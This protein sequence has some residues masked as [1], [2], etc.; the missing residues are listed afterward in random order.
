MFSVLNSGVVIVARDYEIDEKNM[1]LKLYRPSIINGSQTQGVI[2][3]FLAEISEIPLIHVKFEL[4][5]STDDDLI[6]EISIA[7]NYQNDVQSVSILGRR[8]VF[9]DLEIALQKVFPE[10]KLQKS[11]TQRPS[12]ENDYISTEKLIQVIAALLPEELWW[13]SE[14]FSKVYVYNRKATCLKD[15]Q[16]IWNSAKD[17][18]HRL[19]A[20]LK[21]AYS[22]YLSVV[23]I[24]YH[25]YTKWKT[26]QNFKGTGL[27]AIVRNNDGEIVEVPD[28]IIFPIL[29]AFSVFVV[30]EGDEWVL[31]IPKELNDIELIQSAKSAYIEI[32]KSKP[33][34]MGTTKA[35]YSQLEQ[36]TRIYKNLI[37]N[38]KHSKIKNSGELN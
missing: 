15:F 27:R 33:H 6:A 14:V 31:K 11:E 16:E 5:I 1:V 25:L 19:H 17:P 4:I 9:N 35:C 10:K 30:K 24:A 8:K 18:M 29:A 28:G 7:R 38:F 22:F 3:D 12:D 34:L 2:I 32:A 21:E 20:K 26:H 23:G 13:K 36:V 37:Q